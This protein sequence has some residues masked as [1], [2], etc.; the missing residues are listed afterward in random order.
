MADSLGPSGNSA[1]KEETRERNEASQTLLE[2][3]QGSSK[4]SLQGEREQA[5]MQAA[6]QGILGRRMKKNDLGIY[7]M[8]PGRWIVRIPLLSGLYYNLGMGLHLGMLSV[9]SD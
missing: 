5:T 6:Y 2:K 1:K 3:G 7:D 9:S 4:N 8:I